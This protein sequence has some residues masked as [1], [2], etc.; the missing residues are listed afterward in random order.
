MKPTPRTRDS[1]PRGSTRGFR[2]LLPDGM[3]I[4]QRFLLSFE[5]PAVGACQGR[6]QEMSRD[7]S[8]CVDA[9]SDLRPPRGTPVRVRSLRADSPAYTFASRIRGRGR[10]KKS[11]VPV[12][13][14]APPEAMEPLAQRSAHRVTVCLRGMLEW[15]HPATTR[16]AESCAA[17][18]TNLSG[19]GAQ[20]FVRQRPG[21]ELLHLSVDLPESFVS[22]VARRQWRRESLSGRLLAASA[23]PVEAAAERLRERYRGIETRVVS[24][25][26]HLEDD[27]GSIYAVSVAFAQPQEGCY[28]LV[29]FLER[30][31][32]RRGLDAADEERPVCTPR[33]LG[34]LRAGGPRESV[35]V[36][37]AA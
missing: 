32:A 20:V 30:Q 12:L 24:S 4:G 34:G 2:A 25:R 16:V 15:R 35:L 3:Q 18:L 8:L 10:L 17:V 7:G 1:A 26:L 19:G 14:L 36:A 22:E 37:S 6:L 27:R 29:R 11:Q 31:A 23:D 5:D 13:L 9:P 33:P 21:S 28:Q